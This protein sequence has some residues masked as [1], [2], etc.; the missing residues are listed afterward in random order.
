MKKFGFYKVLLLLL[1]IVMTNLYL[2]CDDDTTALH[3][4]MM[5]Q[6]IEMLEQKQRMLKAEE[7]NKEKV[8]ALEAEIAE[9]K[10]QIGTE[11]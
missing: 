1:A 8:E 5:Q 11:E 6:K 4:I 2:G 10:K 3:Q 7:E 9:L